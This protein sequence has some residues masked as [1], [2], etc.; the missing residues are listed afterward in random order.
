MSFGAIRFLFNSGYPDIKKEENK[1]LE[2]LKSLF[3]KNKKKFNKS[4]IPVSKKEI[5]KKSRSFD[6]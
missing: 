5:Y 1:M 3:G 4:K 2:W 6:L